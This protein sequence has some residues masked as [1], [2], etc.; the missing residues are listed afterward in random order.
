MISILTIHKKL[1]IRLHNKKTN[2][3]EI[4]SEVE[5]NMNLDI[6]LQ[7][8]TQVDEIFTNLTNTLV[9]A[10]QH[11]TPLLQSQNKNFNNNN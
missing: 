7:D 3:E 2:W 4:R 10:A 5:E 9:L 6:N 1:P 8:P 11:V